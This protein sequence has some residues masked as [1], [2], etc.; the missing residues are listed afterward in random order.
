MFFARALPPSPVLPRMRDSLRQQPGLP[1]ELND[2]QVN[3]L[4]LVHSVSHPI[5][6][7][8]CAR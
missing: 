8:V 4:Q 1:D 6:L 7:Q 3:V 2:G 5:T